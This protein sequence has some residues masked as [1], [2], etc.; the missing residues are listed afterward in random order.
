MASLMNAR[1]DRRVAAQIQELR[2]KVARS[3]QL[4]VD[5]TV[6]RIRIFLHFPGEER[7]SNSFRIDVHRQEAQYEEVMTA[8]GEVL[9]Q[10]HD[11]LQHFRLDVLDCRNN[12]YP[13][14][15][16]GLAANRVL[17]EVDFYEVDFPDEPDVTR[18]LANEAL[19]SFV[20]RS[21]RFSPGT[22]D[23]FCQGIQ[24]SHIKKLKIDAIH[25]AA[26]VSWSLL[27]LAL[28]H[29]ATCL[30]S[31]QIGHSTDNIHSIEN[32]FESFLANNAT[33]RHL[34]LCCFHRGRDGLPCFVA[35]GRGLAINTTVKIL[36][37]ELLSTP[38]NATTDEQ[39]IQTMFAEGLDHNMMVN[40]LTVKMKARPEAADALAN[41]LERM[42]RNRADA[43][44]HGVHDQEDS[45]P[46]LKKLVF[47]PGGNSVGD[48]STA[49]ALRDLFFDRLSQSDVI[50]VEKV[51]FDLQRRVPSLSSKVYDFIRSTKV[52]KSLLLYRVRD[53]SPD[54]K[55][56]NLADA[57]ESNNSIAELEVQDVEFYKMTGLLFQPNTYRI[58]CQCRRNEIA[59]QTLRKGE[60]LS[61]L[62][63]VLARLLSLD[64]RPAD[65]E[66]RKKI[67]ARQLVDQTIA[68][69][70]MKDIAALFAVYGK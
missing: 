3:C 60:N 62:P 15:W 61:L 21:C 67:E 66:E 22:F 36:Y 1:E 40:S 2:E 4:E 31:L 44:T 24:S 18:F 65:D 39:G 33:I 37:L 25:R 58:R 27:W 50:L 41:G 70:M 19:E 51:A 10:D 5:T 69:E 54:N 57:M 23:S 30:E 68:F 42:M 59:V 38:T 9:R 11:Q 55:L 46:I 45:L 48:A 14:F 16:R 29:G 64:D 8:I 63:S 35:L 12:G 56:A 43:A 52:T 7:H 20:I 6:S 28:E 49:D 32:G 17:K 34:H 53:L 13:Q 26:G 47:Y